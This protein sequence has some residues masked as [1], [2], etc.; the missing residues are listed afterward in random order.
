MTLLCAAAVEYGQQALEVDDSV[1]QAH[2]WFAVAIGSVATFEGTQEKIAKGHQYKASTV[3]I[4][5]RTHNSSLKP[6]P[7][8]SDWK[9]L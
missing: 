1:W 5:L 6:R 4:S 9:V 8:Y 3:Q 7:S 2:Q